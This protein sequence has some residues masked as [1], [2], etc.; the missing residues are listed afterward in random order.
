MIDKISYY[1]ILFII[2]S[3][4]GWSMEVILKIIEKKKFIN[5]GFLIGPICP[6][7]GCGCLLLITTLSKYKNNIF[8][9]FGMAIFICSVLEYLTSYIM[10]KIFNARWWDYSTKKYNLNGRICTSTM[11]PFGI[12]GSLVVYIIN[13]LITKII[14]LIS[15]KQLKIITIILLILFISDLIISLIIMFKFKG[16]L[17][18]IEKDGTEE[19]SKK[20]KEILRKR[21]YL[22]KR[23]IDAFPNFMNPKERLII[24]KQ[25][26]EKELKKY[27]K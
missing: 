5:R 12:L 8:V 10:E 7:Y 14:Y 21:S 27:L 23:L 2:Y 16:T 3:F 24:L 26:I 1:F 4:L 13:P 9:L 17:K 18:T 22:Y 11:I 19:I 25:S 15:N 6:I 20:V